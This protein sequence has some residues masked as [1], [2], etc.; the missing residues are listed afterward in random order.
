MR[1]R[2]VAAC[3]IAA[4]ASFVPVAASA[5]P[6]G[7]PL[8]DAD[9]F[10]GP[11]LSSEV[12]F[13]AGGTAEDSLW[14]TSG[15]DAG[16]WNI[17]DAAHYG[18]FGTLATAPV[19]VAELVAHPEIYQPLDSKTYG[20]KAGMSERLGCEIVSRLAGFATPSGPVDL[21]VFAPI[22]LARTHG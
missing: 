9:M 10:C 8:P 18:E 7:S 21:T 14:I 15:P 19:P 16:K 13:A 17:V 20:A 11:G 1:V 4:C 12:T 3:L 5:A 22:T 6:S 2:A